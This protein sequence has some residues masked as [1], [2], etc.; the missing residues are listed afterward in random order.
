MCGL[1]QVYLKPEKVKLPAALVHSWVKELLRT[2][3]INVYLGARPV[4][5]SLQL[6]SPYITHTIIVLSEAIV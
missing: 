6:P 4:L 3:I 1:D 2:L 5:A